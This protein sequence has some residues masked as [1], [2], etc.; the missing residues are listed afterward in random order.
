MMIRHFIYIGLGGMLGSIGRFALGKVVSGWMNPGFPWATFSVNIIG[1]FIMGLVIQGTN[2]D[3]DW[4]FFLATGLC[5][6][7]TTFSAFAA[8]NIE[9]LQSGQTTGF[10]LYTALSIVLGLAAF[11]AGSALMRMIS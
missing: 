9:L 3:S 5:G 6:G 11:L 2:R 7:F 1:C 4:R 10:I 8:E